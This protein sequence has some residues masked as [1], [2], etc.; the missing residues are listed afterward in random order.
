MKAEAIGRLMNETNPQSR[1]GK[2]HS[3]SSA[4]AV[5]ETDHE[6]KAYL[7]NA[8]N[9]VHSK[10]RAQT[11]ADSARLRAELHIA[12]LKAMAGVPL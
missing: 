8:R 2:P 4:E 1:E 6:Y 5:V 7:V 11:A 10:L 12:L 3:A 9:I